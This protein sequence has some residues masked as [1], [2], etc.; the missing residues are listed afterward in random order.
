MRQQTLEVEH[1]LET[2]NDQLAA[3]GGL[4]DR[5]TISEPD[6]EKILRESDGAVKRIEESIS[7]LGV[8]KHEILLCLSEYYRL[9]FVEFK[10]NLPAAGGVLERLDLEALKRDLWFPL[11]VGMGEARVAASSPCDPELLE[12]IK[13][14]LGG[15]SIHFIVALPSDLTRMIE[16][17][18]DINPG[19]P[20]SAG[21]T[22]LARLRTRLASD[23]TVLAWYRTSMAKGRTGLALLRTGISFIAISLTLLRV[24]GLGYLSIIQAP[25]LLVGIIMAAEGLSWYLPT[26]KLEPGETGYLP[27]LSTFGTT[28]AELKSTEKGPLLT[29]SEPVQGAEQLRTRWNRLSPVMRRRFFAIDRTDLAEERT[30]LAA[31]RVRMA[32]ARTGLAFTRTGNSFAGL[33]ILLIRQFPPGLWTI[34]YAGLIL[35]GLVMFLEGARWYFPGR[36]AGLE[37]TKT[38]RQIEESTS[39]WDFMFRAFSRLDDMPPKLMV[40]GTHAPGIWGTTGLALE[41]TLLAERRNVK[42]RLRTTLARSRTGLSF[43]R[44]GTSIFSVGLGLLVYFGWG[45]I[46][47]T[48]FDFLLMLAGLFLIA[49]GLHWHISAERTKRQLPYCFED[50]EIRMPDFGKPTMFWKKVIFSYDDNEC[51]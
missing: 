1:G 12:K 40:K 36:R 32:K 29:R 31:Y 10:E 50:L 20:P 13:G 37:S 19:F 7:S 49:D 41:R 16:H 34:F 5:G 42:S 39:I 8:P 26:R 9:P 46:L 23:R 24:F 25:L 6:L 22:P 30:F 2:V 48:L 3:F 44:T 17:I 33:G 14:T 28:I 45:H 21:R 4:V 11:S 18:Q 51:S 43:I 15:L 38:I 27:T 35:T 47:W